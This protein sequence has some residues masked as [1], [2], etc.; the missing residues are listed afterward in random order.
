MG[1]VAQSSSDF[2]YI[3]ICK[4]FDTSHAKGPQNG[5]GVNL[6]HKTDKGVIKRQVI[7]LHV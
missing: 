1:D 5:A 4:Y 2:G 3:T 6:K 7:Y